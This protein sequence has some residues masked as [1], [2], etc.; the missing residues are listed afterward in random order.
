MKIKKD[1]AKLCTVQ[2]TV[3]VQ[4]VHYNTTGYRNTFKIKPST[5]TVPVY[6]IAEYRFI[7]F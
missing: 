5:S 7:R 1:C 2:Y 3:L 4:Y 6:S